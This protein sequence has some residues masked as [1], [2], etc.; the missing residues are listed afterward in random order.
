ML[1]AEHLM[2][3]RRWVFFNVW[4]ILSPGF[5]DLADLIPGEHSEASAG[6]A[7]PSD[8]TFLLLLQHLSTDEAFTGK[9]IPRMRPA[10]QVSP[11]CQ[12]Q[13]VLAG[14]AS[15][16]RDYQPDFQG[17]CCN[18]CSLKSNLAFVAATVAYLAYLD[19]I[20]T[21]GQV[22][23]SDSRAKPHMC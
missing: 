9:L 20:H 12:Q 3:C 16:A 14:N 4:P 23:T 1:G 22:F 5:Y 10:F 18:C 19:C 2:L 11:T 7:R 8:G 15:S 6:N 13:P 21:C 17:H